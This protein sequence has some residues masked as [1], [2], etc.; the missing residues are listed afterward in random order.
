MKITSD[1]DGFV[2]ALILSITA[3]TDA[4]AS[5]A[6]E[7]AEGLAARLTNAEIEG[8]KS[9]ALDFLANRGGAT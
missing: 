8:A 4:H 9:A 1:Y 6:V 3:A 2:K 7:V 5:L